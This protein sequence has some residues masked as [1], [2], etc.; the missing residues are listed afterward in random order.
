L[1]K[2]YNSLLPDSITIIK[3]DQPLSVPNLN[4]SH[5][6]FSVFPNPTS[7]TCFYQFSSNSDS[8]FHYEISDVSGRTLVEGKIS[9]G[10]NG[11]ID[12]SRLSPS[13]Y[14]ISV[15]NEKG[16]LITSPQ[17]IVKL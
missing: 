12:L 14:F 8:H 2:D 9:S 11:E 4:E 16:E 1:T 3:L 15:L 5:F 17:K 10:G 6:S 7:T 13:F